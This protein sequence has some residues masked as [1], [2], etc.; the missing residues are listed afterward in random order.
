MKSDAFHIYPT[1][2]KVNNQRSNYPF[3]ECANGTYLPSHGGVLP[4]SMS[5]CHWPMRL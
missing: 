5:E 1:D 4:A 2:G 3:G